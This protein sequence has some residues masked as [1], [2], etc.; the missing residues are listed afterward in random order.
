LGSVGKVV[1][2]LG[3]ICKKSKFTPSSLIKATTKVVTSDGNDLGLMLVS[4]D[5]D[6]DGMSSA[7][8]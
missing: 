7:Q 6:V 3:E 4:N 8:N 2:N 5:D 1:I